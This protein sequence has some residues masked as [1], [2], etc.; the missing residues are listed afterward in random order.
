MSTTKKARGRPPKQVQTEQQKILSA[1]AALA[2]VAAAAAA[3]AASATAVAATAPAASA[4]TVRRKSVA[5]VMVDMSCHV[6][7]SLELRECALALVGPAVTEQAV[8]ASEDNAALFCAFMANF[9]RFLTKHPGATIPS[10]WHED[11]HWDLTA[12]ER[13]EMLDAAFAVQDDDLELKLVEPGE[14]TCRSCKSRRVLMKLR[15]IRSGDEAM[16][17]F[18]TC[19]DCKKK[20]IIH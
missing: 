20:W 11:L 19:A 15:Q 18:Y 3:A 16:T 8:E 17:Q 5:E 12:T 1:A 10:N 9:E 13:V 2:P 14:F 6:P 4:R 7:V